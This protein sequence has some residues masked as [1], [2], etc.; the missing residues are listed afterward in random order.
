MGWQYYWWFIS[1]ILGGAAA[2][3]I[4]EF[5]KGY[6][7]KRGENIATQHDIHML[8]NQLRENTEITR[9]IERSFSREDF[10]WRSELAFREKQLAEFYGPV[11]G[12]LKSQ[13]Q[14][15]WLWIN[16]Q[17]NEMN[18][19]VKKPMSRQNE[20]V[21]KLIIDKAHLIDGSVMPESF[22]HFVTSTLVFDLYAAP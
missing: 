1:P 15:Y 4:L 7:H 13:V 17:M 14:L 21:R 18:F 20:F 6:F 9:T 2:A 10:L 19:E 11:Y 22:V 12:T 5:T 16:G 3:T 8:Q